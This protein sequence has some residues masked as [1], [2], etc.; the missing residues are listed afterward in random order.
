MEIPLPLEPELKKA[1]VS[2]VAERKQPDELAQRL[3]AW[4]E[5]MSESEVGIDEKMNH[6]KGVLEQINLDGGSNED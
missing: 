3:I 4:M 2:V 6:F 5:E 1:I